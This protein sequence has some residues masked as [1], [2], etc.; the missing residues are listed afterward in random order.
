MTFHRGWRAFA[1]RFACYSPAEH[2]DDTDGACHVICRDT[3]GGREGTEEVF[4]E[5]TGHIIGEPFLSGWISRNGATTLGMPVSESGKTDGRVSQY[6]QYGWL[7]S[8]T[9]SSDTKDLR[10]Q[11]VG[12]QLLAKQ[13]QTDREVGGRRVGNARTSI[14][15]G[16]NATPKISG[17]TKTFYERHGGDD[18]FGEPISAEYVASGMRI[19][20]FEYGRLQWSL[21]DKKVTA[22]PVGWELAI[23][24]GV[25]VSPVDRNH[26]PVFEPSRY[27]QYLGDGVIPNATGAF[28]PVKIEIPKISVNANIE[29]IGIINGVMQTPAN[30][31]NVGWYS[32][33]ARPG[34]WTNVVMAGHRDWW[35]IGP[36]VFWNL[37]L[38]STGDK[39]YLVGKDGKG[40]TY[41]VTESWQVGADINA[42]S[43]I[44]DTGGEMLTLITCDGA[45]NGSEYALRR[46]VRAERI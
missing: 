18:R 38:L 20:W 3:F 6:F 41:V 13:S 8:R 44:S 27:R 11:R 34:D 12:E 42:N 15:F 1:S 21:G 33:L 2:R 9:E 4:A 35:G 24:N 43:I 28:S 17:R 19:Q 31:W 14:A 26:L 36:V 16:E 25:D 5:A 30:A 45:F 10:L 29:A 39:I 32:S 7:L 37:D 23:A 22:A 46:I 40:S